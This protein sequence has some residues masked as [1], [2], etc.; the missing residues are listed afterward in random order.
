M[1]IAFRL[2][3]HVVH[4]SRLRT[5]SESLLQKAARHT[6]PDPSLLSPQALTRTTG[7]SC[8]NAAP[9]VRPVNL[10]E[11]SSDSTP[12]KEHLPQVLSFLQ[13]PCSVFYPRKIKFRLL[14]QN[15]K[16]KVLLLIKLF[17]PCRPPLP[18]IS[19]QASNDIWNDTPKCLQWILFLG[20]GI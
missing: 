10:L 9:S 20:S 11:S 3:L 6:Q 8:P 2:E 12:M 5:N 19:I 15:C 13:S 1:V 17:F 18:S 7:Q 14:F 4:T 16:H